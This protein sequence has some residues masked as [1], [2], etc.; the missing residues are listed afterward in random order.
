[1]FAG[2][3]VASF[4]NA[5]SPSDTALPIKGQV[6]FLCT[7]EFFSSVLRSITWL[8]SFILRSS[9]IQGLFLVLAPGISLW[10]RGTKLR[11]TSAKYQSPR[12]VSMIAATIATS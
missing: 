6:A 2:G 5:R 4:R 9:D 7:T 11:W 8:G 10:D 1:M 3:F 12:R